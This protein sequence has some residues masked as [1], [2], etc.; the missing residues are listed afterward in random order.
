MICIKLLE[1]I[2]KMCWNNLWL[3][4]LRWKFLI[5]VWWMLY[6]LLITSFRKKRINRKKKL[7]NLEKMVIIIWI[8]SREIKDSR[9]ISKNKKLWR[10]W[11]MPKWKDNWWKWHYRI[12]Y[13][14]NTSNKP[15]RNFLNKD[16]SLLN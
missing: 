8:R 1:I 5:K 15:Y 3:R 4:R 11:K 16:S 14:W 13:R 2:R 12:S 6:S 9:K 7:I 10:R